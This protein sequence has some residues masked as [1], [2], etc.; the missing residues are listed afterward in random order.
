MDDKNIFIQLHHLQWLMIIGH[1]RQVYE[2]IPQP[3]E[4]N[5][6]GIDMFIT[7]STMVTIF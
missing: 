4:E 7:P 5:I 1:R 2:V 6:I 3:Y